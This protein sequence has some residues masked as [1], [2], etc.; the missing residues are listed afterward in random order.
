MCDVAR[1]TD[2]QPFYREHDG[3]HYTEKTPTSV[4]APA[5]TTRNRL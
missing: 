4:P 2:D 5:A 3:L 1:L